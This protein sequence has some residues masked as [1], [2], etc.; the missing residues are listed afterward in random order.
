M[1]GK[2]ERNIPFFCHSHPQMINFDDMGVKEND[3]A[4]EA[5]IQ[6]L[7]NLIGHGAAEYL[8]HISVDSAIFSFHEG[9]L[10]VLLLRMRD[11]PLYSLPGGYV[12]KEEDLDSAALRI[13]R[14]R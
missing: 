12:G 11:Q 2:L 4:K 13:L 14:E 10:K 3:I 9:L 5:G 1:S 6:E 7:S 8:P